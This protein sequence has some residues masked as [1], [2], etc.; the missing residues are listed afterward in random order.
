MKEECKNI[1]E[2]LSA[3]VDNELDTASEKEVRQHLASCGECAR[4]FQEL[5][6]VDGFVSA[7]KDAAP[8][9][10]QWDRVWKSVD[11]RIEEIDSDKTPGI[12]PLAVAAAV[13]LAVTLIFANLGGEDDKKPD[14]F[15]TGDA[16]RM[17][18]DEVGEGYR[19]FISGVAGDEGPNT[20][21]IICPQGKDS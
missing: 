7:A 15:V 18:I 21:E 3:L 19:A 12:W 17:S 8:S 6:S 20:I 16:P 14:V 4:L 2:K 13:L 11:N 5:R 1:L 10:E 9:D